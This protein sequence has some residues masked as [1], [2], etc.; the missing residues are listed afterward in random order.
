MLPP[1]QQKASM[2]S[3]ENDLI[4]SMATRLKN[5]EMTNKNLKE[6]LKVLVC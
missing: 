6:E 1:R 4:T 5:V 3:S 2:P